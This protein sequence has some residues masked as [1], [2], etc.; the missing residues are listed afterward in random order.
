VPLVFQL[1]EKA[2]AVT[3]LRSVC[4]FFNESHPVIYNYPEMTKKWQTLPQKCSN[5][6]RHDERELIGYA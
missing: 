1:Q 4:A 2:Q 6:Y 5:Q 3:P